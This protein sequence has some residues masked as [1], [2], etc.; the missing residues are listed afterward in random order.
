MSFTNMFLSMARYVG[1]N[2]SFQEV[3]V[4]PDWT[5]RGDSFVLSRHINV[6]VDLGYQGR[7]GGGF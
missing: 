5:R 2:A 3:K 6:N 1:L 4:P 7:I